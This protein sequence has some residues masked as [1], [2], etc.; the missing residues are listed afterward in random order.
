MTVTEILTRELL[1]NFHG[2]KLATQI[3]DMEVK[4]ET[5]TSV[6]SSTVEITP[7]PTWQTFTLTKT[8]SPPTSIPNINLIPAQQWQ[9]QEKN[10]QIN[11]LKYLNKLQAERPRKFENFQEYLQNILAL[12]GGETIPHNS[13]SSRTSPSP[14]IST[15]YMS[16]S[17][18][19]QFSTLLV[20]PSTEEEDQTINRRKR[21]ISPST[22]VPV[23]ATQ[24]PRIS[25]DLLEYLSAVEIISSFRPDL[26]I[27]G[28]SEDCVD[29]TVTVIVTPAGTCSP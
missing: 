18:P 4:V 27:A 14:S 19:G 5:V 3:L 11:K 20:T 26:A 1:V 28:D 21:Q 2:T 13:D 17:V 15:V 23:V 29:H 16:G 22:S 7:T 9:D 12:D 25:D 6:I 8:A 24:L 10:K